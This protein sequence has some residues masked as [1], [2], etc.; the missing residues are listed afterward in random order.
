MSYEGAVIYN[1]Q[2]DNSQFV[3]DLNNSKVAATA[4]GTAIGNIF[5]D[6]AKK[7]TSS[8]SSAVKAM[9][10]TGMEYNK[11]METY[12]AA[13]ST[14]L[15]DV[16]KAAE[17]METIKTKAAQTPFDTEDLAAVTQLLFNYGITAEQVTSK[18]EMLGDI[19]QGNSEKMM[20]VATAYGQMSSAGKVS[21]EDIKQMIE[22]GF[23]PLQEITESTG[24]SMASLYDRISKGTISV[25][26]ITAAMERSTSEGGKY[27]QSMETQSKTF[28]GQLSTAKD[29][30]SEFSGA[31][32]DGFFEIGRSTVLP[33]L[34][35]ELDKLTASAKNG[36]IKT[37]MDKL[38]TSLSNLASKGIKAISNALPSI[39]N[40]ISWI[41]DNLDILAA[42]AKSAIAAFAVNKVLTTIENVTKKFQTA[43]V[44]VALYNM[45][46]KSA[47][48]ANTEFAGKLSLFE[49]AVGVATGK[50]T[51]ATAAQTLWNNVIKANPIGAIITA[52]TALVAILP[53]L[54]TWLNRGTEEF[55][56]QKAAIEETKT[57]IDNFVESSKNATKEL[58]D[59]IEAAETQ[60]TTANKLVAKLVTLEKQT[61][62]TSARQKEMQGIVA[63][64]NK[65]YP[66]LNLQI[67]EQTGALNMST[68][69]IKDYISA[70]EDAI[71]LDYYQEERTRLIQEEEENKRLLAQAQ[72]ELNA[73]TKEYGEDM[74]KISEYQI[75]Q[76]KVAKTYQTAKDNL[77]AL[78]IA[79]TENAENLAYVDEQI[80]IY[81][82][83]VSSAEEAT[84]EYADAEERVVLG[85]YDMTEALEAAGA[86]A[87]EAKEKFNE[88]ADSAQNAFERI[89]D[90][91]TL[92]VDEMI[93]NLNAN[94][95]RIASWTE[96]LGI[97]AE[98]GLDEGLLQALRDLGPEAAKTV[99]NLATTTED[100]LGLLND[101]YRNGG[102]V[103]ANALLTE[104]G[105]PEVTNSGAQ[106][107][108]EISA[109]MTEET[110]T[111]ENAAKVVVSS[112][113]TV[114]TDA[115]KNGG[116]DEIGVAICNGVAK[117]I[118]NGSSSVTSAAKKMAQSAYTS[119]KNALDIHSPS[120]VFEK[121]AEYIPGGVAI[122]VKKGTPIA[123][124]AVTTM[125]DK[126]IEAPNFD[127]PV[128]KS[129]YSTI[130]NYTS[131]SSVPVLNI[132][133]TGSVD[134]D[135]FELGK[136]VLRNLDDAAAFTLRGNR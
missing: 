55:R 125:A 86:S 122:G 40:S 73:L 8:L 48:Q 88:Y 133:M 75:P 62:K 126:L 52:I 131:A 100:K 78:T 127:I 74:L 3:A 9:A 35:S 115:V 21:L 68:E 30:F 85:G 25:D 96:N 56:A 15:G 124:K 136:I 108:E 38:T 6:I 84:N 50:I 123:E 19:A 112:V 47:A 46:V 43:K 107:I 24:E 90:T 18:M 51:L 82:E 76:S 14:M 99:E 102:K 101:A 34:N 13:F 129:N 10:S 49:L 91:T 81:S 45:E 22:A 57:E 118:K 80:S 135:G 29:N 31:V 109:G 116:F 2:G 44:Q 16:E 130:N 87:E 69:A 61:K 120:K 134:I 103:A 65:L 4:V 114:M 36:K 71:K 97:L 98:K 106:T 105:L 28:A 111:A 53:T 83:I 67:D 70:S 17:L 7:I 26:E 39:I 64:L 27:F 54:T 32:M 59:N 20:R 93:D 95:S 104:L 63:Q 33:A 92:T 5:S 79:Q 58:D 41:I 42:A 37:A 128:L 23:N 77:E 121:L 113:K 119:A 66:N 1:I 11:Q 94:Q 110:E 132:S 12:Q 72:E 60:T 89:K 117:G